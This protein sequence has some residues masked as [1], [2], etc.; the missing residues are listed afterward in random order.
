MRVGLSKKFILM[1]S[2]GTDFCFS[3]NN[4]RRNKDSY[5]TSYSERWPEKWIFLIN[6]FLHCRSVSILLALGQYEGP[7]FCLPKSQSSKRTRIFYAS[8]TIMFLLQG[9][10]DR[11]WP[12]F[13]NLLFRDSPVKPSFWSRHSSF[14]S[15]LAQTMTVKDGKTVLVNIKFNVI[16]TKSVHFTVVMLMPW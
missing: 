9:F 16:A 1:N 14:W 4:E 6:N 5:W 12:T 10:D 7:H 8:L 11:S 3:Q 15:R 13:R 2:S